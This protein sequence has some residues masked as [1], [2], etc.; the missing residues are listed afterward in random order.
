MIV[1]TLSGTLLIELNAYSYLLL[2]DQMLYVLSARSLLLQEVKIES[3]AARDLDVSVDCQKVGHL[4][5]STGF[6]TSLYF[7]ER[8]YRLNAYFG[9][10]YIKDGFTGHACQGFH[11]YSIASQ[12]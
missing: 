7:C 5:E 4:A 2:S 3:T 9:P 12:L 8:K 6:G 1:T 11:R 10:V